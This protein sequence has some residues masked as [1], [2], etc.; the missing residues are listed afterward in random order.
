MSTTATNG[1]V[2]PAVIGMALFITSEVMFF[3]GLLSAYFAVRG[4]HGA[5]PPVSEPAPALLGPALSTAV[6][7][8][9]SVT[10]HL[11][12]TAATRRPP[13]AARRWMLATLA[14]GAIFLLAQGWEWT[15]LQAKG[16]G[17]GSSVFGTLFFTITGAHGLHLVGGLVMIVVVAAR[18]TTR[19]LVGQLEA[20]TYY[21]HFVDVVWLVL[22]VSLYVAA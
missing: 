15:E 7:V 9:S 16:L 10:Q 17:V 2:H 13:G 4:N 22:F 8:G 11:A 6:L 5:W 18:W 12:V 3:G 19:P 1:K 20:V 14:L 21:W